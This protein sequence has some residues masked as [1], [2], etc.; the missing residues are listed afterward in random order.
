MNEIYF[1]SFLYRFFFYDFVHWTASYQEGF[2]LSVLVT[3]G[4]WVRS[5]VPEQKAQT[6]FY[7]TKL[8]E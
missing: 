2:S 1:T 8:G 4:D 7:L 6:D 5:D 3:G